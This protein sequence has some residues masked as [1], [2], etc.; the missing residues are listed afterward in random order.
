MALIVGKGRVPAQPARARARLPGV[1]APSG[2]VTF[3]FTDIEGS[4]RLWDEH[5]DLMG[6]ALARHDEI[7]RAA[8][9]EY[10]GHIFA[11][12][13]D[14]FGAAF[15]RPSDAVGAAVLT[16]RTLQSE[17]SAGVNLRVRMGLHSGESEE[18]DGDY[19]GPTVNRAARVMSAAHG[20]Q[21]VVSSTTAELFSG[22][23]VDLV[24]LGSHRLKGLIDALRLFGV[25]AD[26]LAWVD[27]PLVTDQDVP[28]NLPRLATEF[29]G[30]LDLLTQRAADLA[31]R[32]VV[33]LTGP[34]GVGKTRA[35]VEVGWL[36]LHQFPGGV[37]MVELASIT[38]PAAVA[39]AV[40]ATLSV[41]PQP[42]MSMVGAI[43]DWLANRRSLLILDNCEHQLEPVVE[44]V[45]AI[46]AGSATV[47]VLATSREPLGVV[48]ERV[49]P[50]AS[51]ALPDAV[52]LFR[53]RANAAD[54]TF[55]VSGDDAELIDA[56]CARLDG[57]PL[58][59]ELAAA[60]VRS[61]T[62]PDLAA[63]LDDRFR[64]LRGGGRGGLERH[65]TL[66]AAVAWSYDL[67]GQAEQVLFARLATFG[68][69]FDLGA[70]EA[71]CTDDLVSVDDVLDLLGALVDKSMVIAERGDRSMRYRLLETLRQYGEE[72]LQ[73]RGETAAIRD[74]H[75]NHFLTICRAARALQMGPRQIEAVALFDREWDN[76]RSAQEWAAVTD[77]L[78]A[79]QA[80]L[81]ATF[82]Y[83]WQNMPHEH[84]EWAER[85]VAADPGGDQL[86]SCTYLAA[87]TWAL[88][89]LDFN[90]QARLGQAGIRAN[91][92]LSD[93]AV[94]G[95][96]L[97]TAL[98]QRGDLEEAVE[99]L[100]A[101]E[102]AA[103]DS[104]DP[105]ATYWVMQGWL[106]VAWYRGEDQSN[107]IQR[108]A[109]L[110]EST[111]APW[112]LSGAQLCEAAQRVRDGDFAGALEL[113]RSAQSLAIASGFIV[114]EGFAGSGIITAT[115]RPLGAN[116]TAECTAILTR[117]HDARC[118][119]PMW[120]CVESIA[121][122]AARAGGIEAAATITGYLQANVSAWMEA[123]TSRDAT[124]AMIH[125]H[126]DARSWTSRG[127]SM[128]ADEVFA[129]V[130]EQ[131]PGQP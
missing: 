120:L 104:G 38:H 45:S 34:G 52:A 78:D 109:D 99:A 58:A 54:D 53:D 97:A 33:T 88:F 79:A 37:W 61:L 41:Q 112:V 121:N 25:V 81:S 119:M 75:L 32:R 80:L 12:G 5:P 31:D 96:L 113:Y 86:R 129:L 28:G 47:T 1:D 67:L 71:V 107:I 57:I 26:G 9:H 50:V 10:R 122:Y 83:A 84:A 60:R 23:G 116:P 3:L 110:A 125:D 70:A 8:V 49:V 19:F 114:N 127:A 48:G 27:R 73:D 101:A 29:V 74:R 131:L 42:G 14:G 126:P 115:L 18:R 66:R 69:G 94:C 4:T 128:N 40:A 13:G 51:L 46:V 103:D 62:L 89:A 22:Q 124:L 21:V 35:S 64:I 100:H 72:R 20:G 77:D 7:V 95:F 92:D 108:I 16:Q 82:V 63:R 106:S 91:S 87:G 39:S 43:V 55:T 105:Y 2:T 117:L 59:I 6:P 85:L 68:G 123:S 76:V 93:V 24:D 30:R 111:G 118:W 15:Q 44:L 102:A 65:Q 130:M 17:D 11:T 56:I 36:T 98:I 90:R